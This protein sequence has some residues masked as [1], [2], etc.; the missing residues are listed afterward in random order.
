MKQDI[1]DI[2]KN[3]KDRFD[4]I[5]PSAGIEDRFKSLL[6][7]RCSDQLHEPGPEKNNLTGKKNI[8][9][10]ILAVSS[11]AAIITIMIFSLLNKPGNDNDI[12]HIVA[13]YQEK[14]N[15]EAESLIH[16]LDFMDETNRNE[17]AKDIMQLTDLDVEELSLNGFSKEQQK[18]LVHKVYI[19]H[20]QSLTHMEEI[21][22]N[23]SPEHDEAGNKS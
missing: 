11:A 14:L 15:S 23:L 4:D 6:D 9:R 10:I 2:I 1:T 3:N 20:R 22:R 21:I 18:S 16:Q 5:Q 12:S 17:L 13:T 8:R 19:S 7:S